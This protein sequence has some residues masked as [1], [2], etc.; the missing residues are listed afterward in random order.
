MSVLMEKTE[1]LGYLPSHLLGII[2]QKLLNSATRTSSRNTD[3]FTLR[4]FGRQRFQADYI[5]ETVSSWPSKA[6]TGK[7]VYN[8][9]HC[10][11]RRTCENAFSILCQYF[12]IFFTPIA[13][14]PDT[15]VLIVLAA[16]IVYNFLRDEHS[17]SFCDETP[18]DVMDLPRNIQPLPRR[19]GNA[20][21]EAYN[22]RNQFR[23]YFCSRE[24]Q[25]AWQLAHVEGVNWKYEN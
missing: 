19:K 10:L 8:Y 12:R 2:F 15:T 3:S 13:I 7:A 16:C 11:A 4:N 22:V 18:S 6:D 25:V 17:S 1:M 9:R 14:D 21:F 24:G 20:D 23:K 5:D